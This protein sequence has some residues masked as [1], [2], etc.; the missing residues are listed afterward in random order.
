MIIYRTIL[1]D[2]FKNFAVII[3]S[4]SVLLFMEKFVRLTRLFMGK[5][6]DFSDVI[7]I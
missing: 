5:G 7:K 1:K 2:L 4:L 6:A 3:F